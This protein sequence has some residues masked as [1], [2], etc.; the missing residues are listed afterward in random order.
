[1]EWIEE[2]K[3]K[4]SLSVFDWV[5]LGLMVIGGVLI[6]WGLLGGLGGKAPEVEYLAGDLGD[7]GEMVWVDVAGAV[8]KPGVY[9]LG[10]GSRVKDALVAAG[11]LSELAER[12]YLERVINMAEEVKDGQKIYI[13][14]QGNDDGRI[15]GGST[16]NLGGLININTANAGELDTLWGVGTVRAQSIIDNRPFSK[17]EELLSKGVLPENVYERIKEKISVF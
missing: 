12:D 17:V 5:L 6:L 2:L 14:R 13:P 9:E 15:L 1:M 10:K 16:D 3:N 11:G 8:E 7:T 4:F